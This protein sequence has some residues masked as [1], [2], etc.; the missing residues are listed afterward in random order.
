MNRKRRETNYKTRRKG[1]DPTIEAAIKAAIEP[2]KGKANDS[3][4]SEMIPPPPPP[5]FSSSSSSPSSSSS[6]SFSSS[7]SSLSSQL[8]PS[9]QLGQISLATISSIMKEVVPEDVK[10]SN[11]VKECMQ[12]CVNELIMFLAQ[13]ASDLCVISR[14]RVITAEEIITA[15]ETL[16]FDEHYYVLMKMILYGRVNTFMDDDNEEEEEEEEEEGKQTSEQNADPS[17]HNDQV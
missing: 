2:R 17:A 1:S 4:L 16:G 14:K 5:L 7:S 3:N 9:L 13:E 11:E 10:I 12:D 15:L 8:P 6:S